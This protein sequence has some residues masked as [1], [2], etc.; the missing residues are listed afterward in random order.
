M[1]TENNNTN[2]TAPA[3]G[4]GSSAPAQGQGQNQGQ[5][6]AGRPG[7]RPAG[8]DRRGGG[9]RRFFRKKVCFFCSNKI[10]T[11]DYKEIDLLRRFVTDRGKILP[12]RITGTCAKHQR[13]VAREIRK[14]RIVAFLPFEDK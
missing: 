8:R 6:P 12:R 2:T 14:A 10:K 7:G 3:A 5:R 4:Q 13:M 1:S 11:C 9:R